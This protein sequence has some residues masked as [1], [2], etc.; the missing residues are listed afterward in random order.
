[1]QTNILTTNKTF[2]NSS[3]T[4][5]DL[6]KAGLRAMAALNIEAY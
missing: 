1:M 6:N 4:Q 2:G 5:D 3:L